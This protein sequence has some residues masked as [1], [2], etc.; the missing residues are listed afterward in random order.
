MEDI[1]F[2]AKKIC[3]FGERQ[4]ARLQRAMKFIKSSLVQNKISFNVVKYDAKIPFFKKFEL[5]V[6]GQLMDC[7]PSGLKSGHITKKNI[8]SNL[9]EEDVHFENINYNPKCREISRMNFYDFPAITIKNKDVPMIENAKSIDGFLSVKKRN[10]KR[11]QIL[12]GNMKDPIN[13]VFTHVDSLGGEGATDNS[14]SNA[15]ILNIIIKNQTLLETCLFVFDSCEE[16][17]LNDEFYWCYGYRVF[18]KKHLKL[19]KNC[20]NILVIDG[21]GIKTRISKKDKDIKIAFAVK[22]DF[23]KKIIVFIE[24]TYYYLKYGHSKLDTMSNIC[25]Q[26]ILKVKRNFFNM[27][28]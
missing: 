15:L 22:N 10:E 4:G 28:K 2:L 18:E 16:L 27:I 7:L 1:I 6:D 26:D 9:S 24:D 3:S 14:I 23:S 12:I 5:I 8:I 11:E 19:L 17:S 20:Q 25:I 13:I 21:V